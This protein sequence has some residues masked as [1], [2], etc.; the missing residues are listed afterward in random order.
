MRNIIILIALLI[1]SC[2][3]LPTKGVCGNPDEMPSS[4]AVIVNL[5]P[6]SKE[7]SFYLR[8]GLYHVAFISPDK[9]KSYL[10]SLHFTNSQSPAA[11]LIRRINEDIPLTSNKDLFQYNF[12]NWAYVGLI[13]SL[14]M[15]LAERGNISLM[16]PGGNQVNSVTIV[17]DRQKW[18]VNTI[19]YAGQRGINQ[20]LSERGCIAD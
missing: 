20:I 19:L 14:I 6:L 13:D 17:Y 5:Q 18:E 8:V 2:A 3:K 15:G 10:N 1:S 11:N 12:E 9:M 4:K 16:T 7:P